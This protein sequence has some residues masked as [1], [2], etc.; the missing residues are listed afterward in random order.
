MVRLP[1]LGLIRS[2][3]I[4]T[5]IVSCSAA[6][7]TPSSDP[8]ARTS[9]MESARGQ[10]AAP[11]GGGGP[12]PSGAA[13]CPAGPIFTVLPMDPAD[14]RSFRPL[15]FP[16]PPIHIFGAKHSA[17]TINLPGATPVSGRR[18]LFPSDAIVSD[19]TSTES[20]QGSGYQATFWPCR[21]LK[22]YLFHLGTISPALT[23]AFN[24]A[25]PRCQ[26]FD[27]G[28]AGGR[29]KKCEAKVNLPV[30]AGD[31]VGGS[32][33]FAGV[34]WGLVD[35]RTT[36]AFANAK[37]YDGEY[38]HMA[39]PVDYSSS[40]VR[41]L[42]DPK[43]AGMDGTQ[44]RTVAPLAG[45]LM[46]DAAGT[47]QGNWFTPGGAN[48]MNTTNFEPFLALLHDHVDPGIPIVSMG[49]SVKGM[50]LGVYTFTPR[51][52]GTVDRDFA[53]VRPDG[54]TYCYERFVGGQ[55][56]S[57]LNLGATDGALL[58]TMPTATTLRV[59]LKRGAACANA[60][61]MGPEAFSFE[62]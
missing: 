18:V 49:S 35:F 29:V 9:A 38:P 30:R 33:A 59:E 32:D 45:T 5:L 34:D 6:S 50:R 62:R 54:Q 41:A 1:A 3:L 22:S 26:D 11:S 10:P 42:L 20:T 17:F 60:P 40:G 8:S 16:A 51:A 43:I 37:R 58:I 44:R 56:R 7:Q 27:F 52:S 19:I 12:A 36:L 23:A 13:G 2:A 24:A 28:A 4:V 47:A 21:D 14:F 15:G 61:A 53:D 31:A 39:S 46:Q 25:A 57:G 48:F 55:T